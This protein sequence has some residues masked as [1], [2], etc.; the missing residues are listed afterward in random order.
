MTAAPAAAANTATGSAFVG[1]QATTV[2]GGVHIYVPESNDPAEIFRVGVQCLRGGMPDQAR[3]YIREAVLAGHVTSRSCFL[4]VISLLSGRTLRTLP[5]GDLDLLRYVRE[6]SAA[7][8][9]DEWTEATRAIAHL[10]DSLAGQELDPN[11]TIKEFGKLGGTQRHLVIQHLE[12]FWS[13]PLQDWTWREVLRVAADGQTSRE[14][15]DRVWKFFQPVPAGPRVREART[16][17][18]GVRHRAEAGGGAIVTAGTVGY[19]AFLASSTSAQVAAVALLALLGGGVLAAWT[20]LEWRFRVQRRQALDER[21]R[22]YRRSGTSGEVFAGPVDRMFRRYFAKYVPRGADLSE[23][24]AGTWAIRMALRDEV[25][26]LYRESRV[27]PEQ[28]AWLIRFL[29]SEVNGQWRRGTLRSE[30]EALRVPPAT[31][32]GCALGALTA[33]AAWFALAG[34]AVVERPLAA[35]AALLGSAVGAAAAVPGWSR[36]VLERRRFRAEAADAARKYDARRQAH[37]RWKAKLEDRP[38]DHEMAFWLDCDRKMLMGEALRH[39]RLAPHSVV[40][41]AFLEA[42]GR[43]YKRA[44]VRNG[45][46]RYTRYELLIFLLTADGVR[47]MSVQLDL[48]KAT[49]HDRGR[50]NYRYDAVTAVEVSEADDGEK[51]FRLTLMNGDPIEAAVTGPATASEETQED[52]R[53][54]TEI[55]LDAAGLHNT[56]H[57]LEGIAA[58]GKEWIG[59][60]RRREEAGL[61]KLADAVRG[62]ADA[63]GK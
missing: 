10:L 46:W 51:T 31:R 15:L 44:R 48:A 9:A 28:V 37:L 18:I 55:S 27:K 38:N 22:R 26:E 5:K 45:P 62:M 8:A 34:P 56:L 58:E 63:D 54:V 25:V 40:A 50:L 12:M 59:H 14:R 47:Q 35:V 43:Y 19:L 32:I 61:D 36:I 29:V 57:V 24:I 17:E 41:H 23:W 20:G 21:H 4:L 7:Q 33:A 3:K 53:Q 49:F 1:V 52:P 39:Y 2:H 42:P 16:P 30:R 13:G 6:Q 60:E 11:V